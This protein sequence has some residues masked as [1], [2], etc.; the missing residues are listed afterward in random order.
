MPNDFLDSHPPWLYLI[1]IYK[2]IKKIL[3]WNVFQKKNFHPYFFIC[4]I[5]K[6]KCLKKAENFGA[7]FLASIFVKKIR[8]LISSFVQFDNL[9]SRYEM[10]LSGLFCS[11]KQSE[12]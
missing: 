8:H 2:Q 10:F 4:L 1:F 6:K 11:L 9:N 3:G 7:I 5:I 12:K